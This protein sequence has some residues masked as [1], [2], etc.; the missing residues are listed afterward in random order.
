MVVFQTENRKAFRYG[1]EITSCY[2][3]TMLFNIRTNGG[4][5]RKRVENS[6]VYL[7]VLRD[8][9]KVLN[10]LRKQLTFH[11]HDAPAVV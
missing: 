4:Q 6:T 2:C 5:S 11:F 8:K 3:H 1:Y 10:G 7:H 9:K